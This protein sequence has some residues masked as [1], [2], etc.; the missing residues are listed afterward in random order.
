MTDFLLILMEV[1]GVMV[2][3]AAVIGLILL[4]AW[5]DKARHGVP[6]IEIYGLTHWWLK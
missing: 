6:I 3:A 5:C 1:L 4:G 2:W